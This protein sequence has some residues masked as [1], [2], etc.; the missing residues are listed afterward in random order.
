MGNHYS[1]DKVPLR[2]ENSKSVSFSSSVPV[3]KVVGII[4]YILNLEKRPYMKICPS[5][6]K[7]WGPHKNINVY[8][9]QSQ[10]N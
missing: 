9:L 7:G 3:Y 5:S 6:S 1:K 8:E 2:D 10:V 4:C